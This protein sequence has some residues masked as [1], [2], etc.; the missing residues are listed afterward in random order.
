M[1]NIAKYK[2]IE[3]YI[4]LEIARKNLKNGDQIMTEEQLCK[5]FN[6]SRMTINKALNHL[7]DMG[8]IERIPGKGSFV[9]TPHIQKS[10]S[11]SFSFTEDMKSIGLVAG[12]KLVSYEVIRSESRPDIARRLKLSGSDMIHY[13]VRL[14]TGNGKPIAIS[15]TYVSAKIIPA[16]NVDCLNSSF[17]SFVDSLGLG[18]E[19]KRMELRATLPTQSQKE[20]LGADN[21]ALLCSAHVTYTRQVDELIPYEY[22]ETYYNGDIYTY[23][24]GTP[25]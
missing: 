11:T 12:A 4:K 24:T 1:T 5:Q 9:T 13:F 19:V 14:R 2:Q 18:R 20:L 8:Y 17:Y 6:F 7:S 23:T 25:D 10:T 16:I 21:I 22:T 15:Y 3:D